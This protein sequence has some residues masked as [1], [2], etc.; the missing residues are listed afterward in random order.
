MIRSWSALI[1]N[2]RFFPTV[3][4]AEAAEAPREERVIGVSQEGISTVESLAI[5]FLYS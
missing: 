1:A 2:R 5:G 4:I 3:W